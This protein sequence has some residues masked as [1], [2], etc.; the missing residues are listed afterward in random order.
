MPSAKGAFGRAYEGQE[1]KSG[2]LS[3]DFEICLCVQVGDLSGNEFS[4]LIGRTDIFQV[5]ITKLEHTFPISFCFPRARLSTHATHF[6]GYL[7]HWN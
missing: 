3:A 1:L 2:D 4:Y 7:F 5:V 6:P